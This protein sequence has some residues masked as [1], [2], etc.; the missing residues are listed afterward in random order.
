M[1]FRS[2]AGSMLTK[3]VPDIEKTAELVQEINQASNE[4]NAG[5]SQVNIAIQ[6]LDEVIQRN[7]TVSE[8]TAGTA[9][10]LSSQAEHLT[11]ILKRFGGDG[12]PTVVT[13]VRQ[14]ASS[15]PEVTAT[16]GVNLDT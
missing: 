5:A 15:L 8:Q 16:N 1:L 7:A 3:L 10:D 14:S 12:Q 13:V 11:G 9:Q 2:K 4:Q 6:A